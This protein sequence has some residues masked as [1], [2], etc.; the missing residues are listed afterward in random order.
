MRCLLLLIRIWLSGFVNDNLRSI[1]FGVCI[2]KD[3]HADNILP[4]YS[5]LFISL[6]RALAPKF[7]KSETFG[8]WILSFRENKE[9]S[10]AKH[11]V[12]SNPSLLNNISALIFKSQKR[13]L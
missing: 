2:C 1:D 13:L 10:F 6:Q 11:D 5:L 4:R 12:S 3:Q 7:L 8:N 9:T